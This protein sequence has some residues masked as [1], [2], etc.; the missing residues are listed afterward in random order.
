MSG[1][2]VALAASSVM[3][4]RLPDRI[5]LA[6]EHSVEKV[7]WEEDYER[8]DA[9]LVLTEARVRGTGAGMDIPDGAVFV[10]GVWRYRPDLSPLTQ[11]TITNVR[12]PLG[13]DVCVAAKCTRLH[14]LIPDED[15]Q[16][17]IAPCRGIDLR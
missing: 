1:I 7:R 8:Q 9:G 5:T 11:I 10:G 16:L 13:Y 2:C 14:E 12:L 17:T 15:R 4:L 3:L 6:W